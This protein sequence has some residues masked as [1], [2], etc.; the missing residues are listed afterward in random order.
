MKKNISG[1]NTDKVLLIV[2]VIAVVISI[3]G[4]GITYN[5]LSTFRNR[6]TGFA[7]EGGW[8]NLTIESNAAINFTTEMVNW[9]R[10]SVKDGSSFAV[11][12]TSNQS[13]ANITD[14]TWLSNTRGLILENIGNKNVSLKIKS[15]VSNETL[16]GPNPDS[17][18]K[19]KFTNNDT[20]VSCTFGN[21][22]ASNNTWMDVNLTGDGTTVC[23]YFYFEDTRDE[24]KIDFSLKI[25]S[26]SVTGDRGAT[27]TATFEEA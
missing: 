4:A 27:I 1:T 26:T 10:G 5:Y 20:G 25:P 24:I 12:D 11:L 14:G 6:L 23:D 7:T 8:V 22:G 16:L 9:S 19:W 17:W 3:V 15:S 18:F 13:D 21:E 2:A